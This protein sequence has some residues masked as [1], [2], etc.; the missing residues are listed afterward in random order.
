MRILH[1]VPTYFPAVR[2]GGPIYSVH[3]LCDALAQAGHDVHVFTTAV[4][5]PT[6]L[7]VPLGQE[8][9]VDGVKVH[10][11]PCR[12]LRRLYWSPPLRQ[13]LVE[14]V[15]TFDIV[16]LHSVFLW[17]TSAAARI[18]HHAQIPYLVAP[19]GMLVKEL[20]RMRG[21]LRKTAWLELIERRTLRQAA[22]IHATSDGEGDAIREFGYE[23][24][25]IEVV[26]NGVHVPEP[27]AHSPGV[28]ASLLFL[29][30]ISWKKGLDRLIIALRS[31]EGV[32]LQIAGNDDEGLRPALERLAQEQGVASRV[33]FLGPVSG[34]DKERLLQ[35]ASLLV[36][37]SYNENFGNVVL[38]SLAC[39]RPVA[40]TREVGLADAVA[41]AGAGRV[42][43]GDPPAMAADLGQMLSNPAALDAMG[44][45][46]RQWVQDTFAW[47]AVAAQMEQVYRRLRDRGAR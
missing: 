31:L 45:K 35:S 21:R 4:D 28:E 32:T 1:V 41:A 36:L 47:P 46:G 19:R 9:R 16:H 39:G 26:P 5:G 20:V 23:L 10:Y 13:A 11:F 12:H 42:I 25:A 22:A 33:R 18:A 2:Y 27:T 8:V 38:E 34:A 40:V 17:P 37:P 6:D 30:R 7:A 3:G 15:P 29:G 14:T 44:L 43:S 24:P